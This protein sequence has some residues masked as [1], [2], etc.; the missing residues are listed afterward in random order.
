MSLYIIKIIKNDYSHIEL[1]YKSDQ[2]NKIILDSNFDSSIFYGY[3]N[4]DEIIYENNKIIKLISRQLKNNIVGIIELYSKY[5]FPNNNRGIPGYIFKPLDNT[6]PKFIVHTKIKKTKS[7]NQLVSI[8]YKTWINNKIPYGE[9]VSI[10][11]DYNNINS[12]ENTLLHWYELY[13]KKNL[14]ITKEIQL[15]TNNRVLI[16]D[17]IYT[18]DPENCKD[19]DDGF[20]IINKDN[21]SIFKIHI[22]DVYSVLYQNNILDHVNNYTSIYLSNKILH[23]IDN[24]LSINMCSLLEKTKR[25]MITLEIYLDNNDYHYKFYHSYG[26]ITKNCSY[27]SYPLTIHK[28][29]DKLAILYYKITN[30]EFIINDSHTFIEALMI[31]YNKLFV[32]NLLDKNKTPIYRSQSIF[33]QFIKTKDELSIFLDII[34]SNSAHYTLTNNFHQSLNITNY[35]HSTSPIRRIIDLINQGIFSNSDYL[36]RKFD[37]DTINKYNDILKKYYRK[38]NVIKLAYI[39]YNG[40]SKIVECYIYDFIDDK[41]EI[42]I[43]TYNINIRYRIIDKKVRNLSSFEYE[44]TDQFKNLLVSIDRDLYSIPMNTK[45]SVEINGNPDIF[46]INNSI[47]INMDQ[48]KT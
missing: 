39:L 40:N 47:T 25:L 19:I 7:K 21:K 24:N 3:F 22:S 34:H 10:Y 36:F 16:T 41:L 48:F 33:E 38:I 12:I 46:S 4:D 15:N 1:L 42:F 6:L 44:E 13:P 2:A 17:K 31:I 29:F 14:N 9:L 26:T 28:Y 11:G 30:N 20:S 37:L 35:T 27:E 23:M 18:I 32:N 8:R 43:P 5:I 45:I